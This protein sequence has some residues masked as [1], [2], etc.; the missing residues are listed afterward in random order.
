[1]TASIASHNPFSFIGKNGQT[2]PISLPQGTNFMIMVN[3]SELNALSPDNPSYNSIAAINR[4]IVAK[5]VTDNFG[6]QYVRCTINN[7]N[8]S[9]QNSLLMQEIWTALVTS[10]PSGPLVISFGYDATTVVAGSV[11]IIVPAISTSLLSVDSNILLQ[12]NTGIV[13]GSAGLNTTFIEQDNNNSAS[14]NNELVFSIV[15]YLINNMPPTVVPTAPSISGIS[16]AQLL[17]NVLNIGTFNSIITGGVPNIY[18][19]GILVLSQITPSGAINISASITTT[20]SVLSYVNDTIG[21][22]EVPVMQ[23]A[24]T[25]PYPL[26]ES[27]IS[28]PFGSEPAGLVGTPIVG[29]SVVKLPLGS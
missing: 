22:I 23:Q 21:I 9:L 18:G 25:N 20:N 19:I 28:T 5:T 17:D 12:D 3:L 26:M 27:A 13:S 8:N 2:P 15:T 10:P 4:N 29:M 6:N 16:P 1:M 14:I 11:V 24:N 7:M